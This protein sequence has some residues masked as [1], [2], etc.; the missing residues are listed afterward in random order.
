MKVTNRRVNA[1]ENVVIPKLENTMQYIA[2]ELDEREREDLYRLKKVV[3]KKRQEFEAANAARL[4]REKEE[5]A[6]MGDRLNMPQTGMLASY[7]E[8]ESMLDEYYDDPDDLVVD[9][10][11][12]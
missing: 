2:S 7:E 11:D 12:E 5:E 9:E 3:S 6:E 10:L 4:K 1:L 8:P